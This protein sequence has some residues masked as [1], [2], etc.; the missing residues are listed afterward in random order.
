M[1]VIDE[2]II[3][4]QRQLLLRHNLRVRQIGFEVGRKGM[5][6]REQVV[7]LLHRLRRVTLFTR[8]LGLYQ[9]TLCHER[10]CIVVLAVEKAKAAQ[11]ILRIL[12]HPH[13]NT[14]R[15]RLG[16]VI[17]ATAAGVRYWPSAMAIEREVS[18]ST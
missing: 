16:K 6:D 13:F 17:R 11:L 10:Y 2:N 12:R 1:I 15:K 9:R 14:Q 5:D 8:D 7:P 3:D 18:W 4:W